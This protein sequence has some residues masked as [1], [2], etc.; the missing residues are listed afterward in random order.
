MEAVKT[1]DVSKE[2]FHSEYASQTESLSG[3]KTY[4]MSDM[5]FLEM[6]RRRGAENCYTPTCTYEYVYAAARRLHPPDQNTAG[7]MPSAR[8]TFTS[9]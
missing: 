9:T 1:T 3:I 6:K 2:T 8:N 5:L 7:N 4:T